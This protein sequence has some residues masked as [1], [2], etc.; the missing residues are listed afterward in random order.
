MSLNQTTIQSAVPDNNKLLCAYSHF[1]FNEGRLFKKKK[2]GAFGYNFD[3]N[4][5][6]YTLSYNNYI[7]IDNVVRKK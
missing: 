3:S 4:L 1:I 7:C 5:Q 6:Q 2:D